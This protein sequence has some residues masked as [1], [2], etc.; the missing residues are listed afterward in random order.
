M[1]V[2]AVLHLLGLLAGWIGYE[3]IMYAVFGVSFLAFFHQYVIIS[4]DIF[5][6]RL[7][8]EERNQGTIIAN[9]FTCFFVMAC[10][11]WGMY[12][13]LGAV[14]VVV[15]ALQCFL[16][17]ILRVRE[18]IFHVDVICTI[19]LFIEVLLSFTALHMA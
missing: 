6:D 11:Y 17:Q 9:E 15:S 16:F 12:D 10:I 1:W 5:Y 3:N 8:G 14:C 4:W 2:L 18:D 7:F 13:K 19:V